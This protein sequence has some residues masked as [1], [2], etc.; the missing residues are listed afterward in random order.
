MF[1]ALCYS[2]SQ[3]DVNMTRTMGTADEFADI[4][5]AISNSLREIMDDE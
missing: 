1:N 2:D 4:I 3:I 5:S